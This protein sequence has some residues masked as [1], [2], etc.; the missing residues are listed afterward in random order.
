MRREL[1]V[2]AGSARADHACSHSAH[3]VS[4]LHQVSRRQITPC[5][6]ELHS[7]QFEGL[8]AAWPATGAALRADGPL[9][10]PE[11]ASLCSEPDGVNELSDGITRCTHL[12]RRYPGL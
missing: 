5:R 10:S 12:E 2:N 9:K 4:I 7:K 8:S 1:S 11:A 6:V 3:S